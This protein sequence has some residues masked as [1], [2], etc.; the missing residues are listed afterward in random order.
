[1]KH[2]PCKS[3][4]TRFKMTN[5]VKTE[6]VFETEA[7][8]VKGI[9]VTVI[10]T[11]YNYEAYIKNALDSVFRQ[12]HSN[13]ELIVV[14]DASQ[15]SSQAIVRTWLEQ[16]GARFSQAKLLSHLNNSGPSQAR[17]TAFANAKYEYVFV[18]DADNEIYSDAI[19]KL[20]S[21]CIL[22]G[23]ETAYSQIE[24]FGD[25]SGMYIGGFWNPTAFARGN[26]IDAMA[27]IKKSA[28]L[29]AGGYSYFQIPGWEDYDLW[30]KFV[31]LGFRGVFMPE[32]L[33]RY[34]VHGSSMLRQTTNPNVK[35]LK[36][37]MTKRHPWLRL[38]EFA[39]LHHRDQLPEG[40]EKTFARP[41]YAS[42]KMGIGNTSRLFHFRSDTVDMAVLKQIFVDKMYDLRSLQRFPQLAAFAENQQS[43]GFRPLIIDAGANIG[44][45]AL[46]FSVGF[47][48]GLVVAIEPERENF[49]LL[50]QNVS[51]LNVISVFGAI[52]SCSGLATVVDP[53]LGP[54]AYRTKMLDPNDQLSNTVPQITINQIYESFHSNSVPFIVKIDIEGAE[55]DLFSGNT[56]WVDRTPLIVIELHDR[57]FPKED[58]ISDSFF[59][60]VSKLKR[61]L[62]SAGELTF[63]IAK[64]FEFPNSFSE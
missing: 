46:Y 6:I 33:C 60:C 56:E 1:M 54:W 18:L 39:E 35:Q 51:G 59:S 22:S 40:I 8:D 17:N 28:W 10:V 53:G 63:S 52:A 29:A 57:F 16:N 4:A 3:E 30:C 7:R 64:D 23:A 31:E 34:R 2:P 26:Y 11:L 19:A 38:S 15:D 37:E 42:T 50:A 55:K 47:P 9:G 58:R 14:D 45:S 49:A 27:L 32:I 21:V 25:E 24:K 12:T 13:I 5:Q 43:K 62:Y 48:K 41:A 20:L 44:A 61:D 36:L